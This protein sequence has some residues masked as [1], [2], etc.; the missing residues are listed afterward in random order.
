MSSKRRGHQCGQDCEFT[1]MY[2]NDMD[3]EQFDRFREHVWK[4]ARD[5]VGLR[6]DA[7]IGR[8]GLNLTKRDFNELSGK[9]QKIRDAEDRAWRELT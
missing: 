1:G 6:G 5:E 7:R 4:V 8:S 9:L 3:G 2:T